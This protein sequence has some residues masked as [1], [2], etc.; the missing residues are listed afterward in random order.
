[1]RLFPKK[2]EYPFKAGREHLIDVYSGHNSLYVLFR[3]Y[4][5]VIPSHMVQLRFLD[6]NFSI[7]EPLNMERPKTF[8]L[9]LHLRQVNI[10]FCSNQHTFVIYSSFIMLC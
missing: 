6:L 7:I 3:I 4:G 10:F 8:I 1:M 9:F 2:V 5:K